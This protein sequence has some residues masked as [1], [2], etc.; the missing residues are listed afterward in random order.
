MRQVKED[1]LIPCQGYAQNPCFGSRLPMLLSYGPAIS[2]ILHNLDSS[3]NITFFDIIVLA[4]ACRTLILC[5]IAII[6]SV[7]SVC[8]AL[9]L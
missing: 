9:P 5:L 2:F 4:S 7:I 8:L 3:P 6:I 1:L